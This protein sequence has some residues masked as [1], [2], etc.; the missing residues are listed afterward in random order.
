MTHRAR[1]IRAGTAGIL[2]AGLTAVVAAAQ[3]GK[4]PLSPEAWIA[5]D[6]IRFLPYLG[7]PSLYINRG[8]A[9]ARGAS[10]E[11]GTLDLDVAASD[12]T[13]FLGVVFRAATPRFSNVL[14]LRPGSSGTAEAV[15]YGPA[16]NS[17]GVAWQVYHGDGANAVVDVARNRWVHIR[18]EL[19]GAVARLYVDT[20]TAPTLVVPRVVASG[21]A[22]LGVW[23]GA[24]GHGAYFSNIRY[25]AAPGT[26]GATS[27]SAPPAGP[28]L[29]WE[30]SNPIEAAD[31]TPAALPDLDR[32]SWQPVEAEPEGFILINR[33][34]EAPIGGVPTDSSGAVLIDSVM[35]G[36]IA[37]SRIVYARTTIMATHD[38]IRRMQ[39]A[40]GNGVVIYLNGR[41]LVF[42]MNPGG[43]RNN[44]GVMAKV[45]D[46][47]Y[48]S[49]KKGKNQL[50]FAVIECTGGWAYSAR[51]DAGE[52]AGRAVRD[53]QAKL[54]TFAEVVN[55]HTELVTY[56][57]VRAVK[58]VPA[59]ET[60]GKDEDML[61]LLD[62][63]DFKDGTIQLDVAGPRVPA[64]PRTHGDS[65]VSAFAPGR[66][67]RGPRCSTCD[68][69]TGAWTTSS[70]AITPCSMPPIRSSRGTAFERRAPASTSP[71][72]TWR[73]GRGRR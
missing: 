55:G 22:G 65:S 53:G 48:L 36:K 70:G 10:M 18:V 3:S 51:L 45:G 40:Y 50:V 41:P 19:E 59:P 68:R 46:A 34:R 67:A 37:G 12:T 63:A 62:G 71:T 69:P 25:T 20:A 61:A 31:F 8:V 6:S 14:F 73:P 17:V 28:M 15:Q 66:T 27:T 52:K 58:L 60:D 29:G 32:L 47:V 26:S 13:N 43:L 38:E 9:L 7:R 2:L 44:L 16:F 39:Y 11:N 1:R 35:T 21:G 42:A 23:A 5:T 24:F 54:P 49:L 33:Y 64:C 56:R 57:G 72:P 4:V 30:I